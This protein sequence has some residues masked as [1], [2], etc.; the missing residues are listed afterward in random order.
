M[1]LIEKIFLIALLAVFVYRC[2]NPGPTEL[3]DNGT[4]T[5]ENVE[6]EVV[7]PNPDTYVYTNGY[8]ST[9]IVDPYIDKTSVISLSGIHYTNF[10]QGP[11]YSA[12]Y[13][14]V[15]NDKSKPIVNHNGR[16]LGFSSR[17][18]GMVRFN[19][20]PAA[21]VPNRIQYKDM[22]ETRDTVVGFRYILTNEMMMPHNRLE[23]PYDSY[24][25][26]KIETNRNSSF[27]VDVPTPPE[28]IGQVKTVG[29]LSQ[30]NF[31]LELTW[32]GTNEGKIEIL[33]GQPARTGREIF[34]L[35]KVT[36]PDKGRLSI[37]HAYFDKLPADSKQLVIT[38]IRRLVKDVPDNEILNDSY[39]IAQSIHNINI[40]IPR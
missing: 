20:L 11:E 31:A 6:I 28:V 1:R 19:N 17:N 9:G 16:Q 7:S 23:F 21:V 24:V 37:S 13:Y 34:P 35:L 14:A 8:D 40:D 12:Y 3:I 2:S 38:F 33:I 4:A 10:D 39:I 5:N 15:F 18:I 29:S 22:Q 30:R 36:G 26:I 32:N 25:N 27:Q